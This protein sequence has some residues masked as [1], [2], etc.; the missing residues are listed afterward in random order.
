[1]VEDGH[2]ARARHH[3]RLESVGADVL[4]EM[5]EE[6]E[7]DGLHAPGRTRDG[8]LG[9]VGLA[10]RLAL[11]GRAVG[12]DALEHHEVPHEIEQV[13]GPEHALEKNLLR[14]RRATVGA[15]ELVLGRGPRGLPLGVEA[16]G[17]GDGP[18]VRGVAAGHHEDLR[19]LEELRC[20][21]LTA[22]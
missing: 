18:V 20:A 10:N 17:R 5:V 19:G 9:A 4:R 21:E 3:L 6:V 13:R 7:R 16:M 11:L 1:V 15:L 8:R 12:E 22:D 14:R 2:L